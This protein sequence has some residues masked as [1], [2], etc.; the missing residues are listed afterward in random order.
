MLMNHQVITASLGRRPVSPGVG[1]PLR[2]VVVD[3]S[4]S[5]LEVAC[6]LLEREEGIEVAGKGTDGTEAICAV[7]NLR[8]DVLLMDIQMPC[9]NGLTAALLISQHFP[10]V[11]I[12]LMSSDGS[13][14]MRIA[15]QSSGA[16]AFVYK[17]EFKIQLSTALEKVHHEP[18]FRP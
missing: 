13:L 11:K 6:A 10:A 7:A 2:V 18:V 16:Q 3:D 1:E 5:F 12:V 15:C 4:P 9:M 8:P 17:P 14:P